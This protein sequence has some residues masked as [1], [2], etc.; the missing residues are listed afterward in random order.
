M[1]GGVWG[2][3][4]P[5]GSMGPQPLISEYK[6]K[7]RNGSWETSTKQKNI[8]AKILSMT[9]PDRQYLNQRSSE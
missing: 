9:Q 1:C 8:F 2:V 4:S 7:I 5:A 6:T 3:L